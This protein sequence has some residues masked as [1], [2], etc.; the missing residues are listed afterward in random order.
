[1]TPVF[2]ALNSIEAHV[3]KIRLLA[4][5]IEA[6][7]GGDYLQGG[8]GELPALGMIRLWVPEQQA[9]Q[10]RLLLSKWFQENDAGDDDSWIPPSLR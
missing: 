3:M 7:V 1:M 9:K 5:G 6:E 4:E 8:M 2:D 10:A